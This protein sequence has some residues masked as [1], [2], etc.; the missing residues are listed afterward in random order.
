M[1]PTHTDIRKVFNRLYL[2]IGP[3][4]A[5]RAA[6]LCTRPIDNQVFGLMYWIDENTYIG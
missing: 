2:F 1:R 6:E 4:A 5:N 3:P